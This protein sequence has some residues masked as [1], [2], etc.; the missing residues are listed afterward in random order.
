[1]RSYISLDFWFV[2]LPIVPFTF[3]THLGIRNIPLILIEVKRNLF[4]GGIVKRQ[5]LNLQ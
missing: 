3:A 2:L 5:E 1:M 4:G